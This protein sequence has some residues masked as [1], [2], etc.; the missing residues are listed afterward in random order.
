MSTRSQEE[1][2][3]DSEASLRLVE[4]ALCELLRNGSSPPLAEQSSPEE[5]MILLLGRVRAARTQVAR[6]P[7]LSATSVLAE[8]ESR[9]EGLV[10]SPQRK[11]LQLLGST[12]VFER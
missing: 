12:A 5:E 2:L 10:G 8:V 1:L 6:H 9:L 11:R 4:E 3:Y 7:E